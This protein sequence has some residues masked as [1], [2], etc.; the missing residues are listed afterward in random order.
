MQN[1]YSLHSRF[2]ISFEMLQHVSRRMD[3]H[4]SRLLECSVP[5][6]FLPERVNADEKKKY[7]PYS[8]Q[9]YILQT[10]TCVND[11][12]TVSMS[13]IKFNPIAWTYLKD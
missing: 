13:R 7:L 5:F 8:I 12:Q 9:K 11:T 2:N 3:L 4:R 1:L 6:S 10:C